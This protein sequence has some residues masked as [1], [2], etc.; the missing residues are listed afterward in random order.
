LAGG[1]SVMG[2]GLAFGHVAVALLL[3]PVALKLLKPT[4][5]AGDAKQA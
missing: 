4:G 1:E 5:L 3:G 2:W